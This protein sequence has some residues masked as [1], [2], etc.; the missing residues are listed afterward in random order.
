[1]K[2]IQYDS[3]AEKNTYENEPN[4]ATKSFSEMKL[5]RSLE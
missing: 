3:A 2:Q 4:S 1:M 5:S